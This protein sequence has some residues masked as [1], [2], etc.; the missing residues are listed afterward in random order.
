[1]PLCRLLQPLKNTSL[2]TA[3][4]DAVDEF[5][6]KPDLFFRLGELV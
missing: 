4:Q 1:V 5:L 2:I 6:S 3:R